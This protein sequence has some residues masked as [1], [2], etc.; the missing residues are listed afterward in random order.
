MILKNIEEKHLE[1]VAKS[2]VA[3]LAKKDSATIVF[4]EG[5]LG[6]GKTTFTKYLTKVLGSK[7]AVKSPTFVIMNEYETDHDKYERV[8]HVD[9]Y[10]LEKGE[11]NILNLKELSKNKKHLIV[12]EWPEKIS[13][14]EFDLKITIK[15]IDEDKRNF[16]LKYAK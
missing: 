5:E 13:H 7:N 16:I 12:V 9:A 10:R 6:S 2:V 1:E 3:S 11:D 4:L 8:F 15:N 14:K